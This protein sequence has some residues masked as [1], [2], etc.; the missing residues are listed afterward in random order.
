M[1][2][3]KNIAFSLQT[4]EIPK[5]SPDHVRGEY[6]G[7]PAQ[8]EVYAQQHPEDHDVVQQDLALVIDGERRE[9]EEE[10]GDHRGEQPAGQLAGDSNRKN[11]LAR[12]SSSTSTRPVLSALPNASN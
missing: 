7:L 10:G 12:C 1:V 5:A 9:I 4:T 3:A 6:P 8:Q 2:G 11:A